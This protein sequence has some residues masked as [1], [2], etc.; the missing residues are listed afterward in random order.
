MVSK[1]YFSN[2]DIDLHFDLSASAQF[3]YKLTKLLAH[4]LIFVLHYPDPCV[5]IDHTLPYT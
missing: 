2:S 4:Q 5:T 3:P 1:I